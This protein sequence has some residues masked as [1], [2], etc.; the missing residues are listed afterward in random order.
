MEATDSTNPAGNEL[1][2]MA[3]CLRR[4]LDDTDLLLKSAAASGDQKFQAAR[5]KVVAQMGRAREQLAALDEAGRQKTREAARATD[6]TVHEHPY[7][8]MA[9]A[10][11]AG[12]LI[13]LIVARR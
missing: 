5:E 6:E 8:A 1:P 13:G 12:V 10:A 2:S 9:V 11:A 7:A 3:E 4:V